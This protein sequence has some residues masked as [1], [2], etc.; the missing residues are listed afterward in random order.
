MTQLFN[1][2]LE[3]EIKALLQE[4]FSLLAEYTSSINPAD[5]AL[6]NKLR[7]DLLLL[8]DLCQTPTALA[9]REMY[10]TVTRLMSRLRHLFQIT[11]MPPDCGPFQH[12]ELVNLWNRAN[13][14]CHKLQSCYDVTDEEVWDMIAPVVPD[15]LKR[16]NHNLYEAIWWKPVPA[17]D[18]EILM[19]TGQVV[20]EPVP[21]ESDST[22]GL[23]SIRF[24]IQHQTEA[25]E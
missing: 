1:L 11:Q 18:I 9:D 2:Q 13:A 17:M 8:N 14:W 20:I 23:V 5:P 6:C 7:Q 10:L 3:A 24:S 25:Q 19:R 16:L 12:T 15:V 21:F 22:P 4:H